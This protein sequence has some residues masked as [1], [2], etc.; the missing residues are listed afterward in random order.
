M[1]E[2]YKKLAELLDGCVRRGS[3]HINVTVG[4]EASVTDK[5]TSCVEGGACSVPTLHKGIDD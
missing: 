3:A 1:N 4:D 2:E 5:N